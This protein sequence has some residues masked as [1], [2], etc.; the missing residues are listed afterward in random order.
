MQ[1]NFFDLTHVKE[2]RIPDPVAVPWI[3]KHQSFGRAHAVPRS[4]EG[5][6]QK[7]CVA[8]VSS[9]PT[10]LLLKLLTVLHQCSEHHCCVGVTSCS[11][12]QDAQ[13]EQL[14]IYL[15]DLQILKTTPNISSSNSQLPAPLC[16]LS[17][18]STMFPV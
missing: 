16:S 18:C 5:E 3:A 4:R 7:E 10:D 8:T 1:G 12:P 15:Q 17:T 9:C 13:V 2:V 14:F 6:K 11:S